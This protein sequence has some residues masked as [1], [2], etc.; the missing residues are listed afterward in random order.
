MHKGEVFGAAAIASTFLCLYQ[1][2]GAEARGVERSETS[3]TLGAAA[4]AALLRFLRA[5][6]IG[7]RF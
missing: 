7:Q 1:V 3:R 2:S 4:R 6:F 5:N